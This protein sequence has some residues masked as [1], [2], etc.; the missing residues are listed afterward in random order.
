VILSWW[1]SLRPAFHRGQDAPTPDQIDRATFRAYT[2]MSH[3][4]GGEPDVPVVFELNEEEALARRM[5]AVRTRL[6]AA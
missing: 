5:A 3:D 6:E 1:V 2:K 4:V